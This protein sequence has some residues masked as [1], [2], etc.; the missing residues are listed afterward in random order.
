MGGFAASSGSVSSRIRTK[1]CNAL[2]TTGSSISHWTRLLPDEDL[3][4][5]L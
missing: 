3:E 2:T 5:G 1:R 4:V